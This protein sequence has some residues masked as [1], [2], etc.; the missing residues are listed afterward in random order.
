MN[1]KDKKKRLVLVGMNAG[2]ADYILENTEHEVVL[3]SVHPRIKPKY[4]QYL[5]KN[6][7]NL[8][9]YD[10]LE[11]NED[12]SNI[13][14]NELE[15]LSASRVKVEKYQERFSNNYQSNLYQYY[16]TLCFW[17]KF[18]NENTVDGLII[19]NLP[20]AYPAEELAVTYAKKHDVQVYTMDTLFCDNN[21]STAI[22]IKN[23]NRSEYIKV[24]NNNLDISSLKGY[25]SKNKTLVEA[26][27][28]DKIAVKN[29]F[30]QSII[31]KCL[32]KL[33]KASQHRIVSACSSDQSS[34]INFYN[35]VKAMIEECVGTLWVEKLKAKS[36]RR[37]N[38]VGR[39]L[40][41][42]NFKKALKYANR[43]SQK[44]SAADDFVYVAMH[45]EPEMSIQN[46]VKMESQLVVLK[47][48]T[49]FLPDGWMLYVKEHPMQADINNKENEP[50]YMDSISKFR[51]KYF[52]ETIVNNKKIKLIDINTNS[53]HI[54]SSAKAVATINGTIA[55]EAADYK[56]PVM[57]FGANSTVLRYC[58]DYIN[59]ES[60]KSCKEALEKIEAGFRPQYN[61]LYD[62]IAG[63]LVLENKKTNPEYHRIALDAIINDINNVKGD[64]L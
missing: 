1:N 19:M 22:G 47:M 23:Y 61:G 34:F 27:F 51:N 3:L 9:S 8:I 59:I 35:I 18:F 11:R 7:L 57:L 31:V 52:Y 38:Y 24:D 42:M 55:L 32:A 17:K 53:Q 14:F 33:S 46:R 20:H 60:G 37:G 29:Q 64:M 63:Y 28:I 44:L 6:L 50:V 39:I 49:D 4:L 48:L 62:I 56:L 13:D 25:Y 12:F 15:S 45:F 2:W 58:E 30:V 43:K 5:G 26:D 16:G 40:G 41:Y 54:M 10:E 21:F 36:N